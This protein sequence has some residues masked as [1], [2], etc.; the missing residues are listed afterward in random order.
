MA[1]D[2]LPPRRARPDDPLISVVVPVYDEAEAVM[3][4]LDRLAP[5]LAPFRH[6]I[7]FVNDGS[8]DGTLSVLLGAA[9]HIPALRIVNLSR[10]FGKEAAMTAGIDQARGD[11]LVIMD[12][13]G[14][15][16][17]ELVRDFVARWRE[18]YD[19]VYGLRASRASDGRLKRV[20][21]GL[22]Y[23]FYNRIAETDI[24]AHVGDFRL[25]DRRVADA[26]KQLPER[27]R[28]M[29][30]LFAWVGFASTAVP[31]E[32]APRQAG[33]T[34]W[35]YWRLWNFALDGIVSFSSAPLRIWTYIGGAVAGFAV[36]YALA[37]AVRTIFFGIDVPGYA[38][39]I[40]VL[41]LSTALNLTSLGIIG[42]YVSR[43]FVEA[44]ARPLYLIEGVYSGSDTSWT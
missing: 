14:Q 38:S 8:R 3:P 21:A 40:I 30:G 36:L 19:I 17:P 7:V 6:E 20:S 24:P 18:G 25:I 34:K 26:L 43:L 44:K 11:A 27:G 12:V 23:R 33:R 35:N 42:E 10:N 2:A 32:R 1:P 16:P 29:K 22:F 13:D 15:D 31:F 37:I 5:V 41:L 39:L 4:C 28:F 9:R